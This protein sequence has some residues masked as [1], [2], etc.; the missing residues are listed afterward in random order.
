MGGPSECVTPLGIWTPGRDVF[1]IT[2][3]STGIAF[4]RAMGVESILL[5]VHYTDG[6]YE[7][8]VLKTPKIATDGI[9]VRYTTDL[10]PYTS[11]R[12]DVVW[13][14][15]APKEMVVPKET[16]RYFVTQTCQI[17]TQCQDVTS[18]QLKMLARFMGLAAGGDGDDDSDSDEEANEAGGDIVSDMLADVSCET[19]KMFCFVDDLSP[20]VQQLCPVT[21]GFCEQGEGAGENVRNPSRYRVT[22]VNYHGHLLGTEMYATLLREQEEDDQDNSSAVDVSIAK[23]KQASV[24]SSATTGR[25]IMAKDLKSQEVWLYDD[26]VTFLMDYEYEIKIDADGSEN[27]ATTTTELMQGVEVK[28]GDKVQTTC[29]YNSMERTEDTIFGT[30]TYEEMCV[31]ALYITFETPPPTADSGIDFIVDLNLRTFRCEVDDENHTTDVWQGILEE[32]E[33]P[34]N[35]Y[36]DHPIDKSDM[37]TFPVSLGVGL[38]QGLGLTDTALTYE[39]RNCPASMMEGEDV[40]DICYG[41]SSSSE[42]ESE[43]EFLADTVVGYTCIGGEHDGKDSNEA[44]AYITKEDC[45]DIGGGTKYDPYTC[46]EIQYWLQGEEAMSLYGD[47][48]IEYLR[49]ELYQPKCC[50]AANMEESSEVE[51]S[52]VPSSFSLSSSTALLAMAIGTFFATL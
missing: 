36:F 42:G 21:C 16:P 39:T 19:L 25:S 26:Q 46:S 49:T 48:V 18:D 9:R 45:I 52:D 27:G 2:D 51:A 24:A 44:P 32:N 47:Q 41:Y 40:D 12:K 11:M 1:G 6:V 28:P 3:N 35:I 7:D 37:C 15:A 31:V 8:P 33:D 13:V 22:G 17:G 29:V 14:P 20:M 23:K 10:R 34:R 50:S 38:W 4:G 43:I 30:S 5:N